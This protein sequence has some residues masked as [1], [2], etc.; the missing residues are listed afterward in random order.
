MYTDSLPAAVIA[1]WSSRIKPVSMSERGVPD[2]QLPATTYQISRP[3]AAGRFVVMRFSLTTQ[4]GP[5]A[6]SQGSTFYLLRVGDEY[7]VVAM[8]AW[9]T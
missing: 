7:K 5:Q 8:T 3:M 4:R 2:D 1:R 9:I 6:Y